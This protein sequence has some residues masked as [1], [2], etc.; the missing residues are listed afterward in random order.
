MLLST[1]TNE[2][3]IDFFDTLLASIQ[4]YFNKFVEAWNAFF[5]D[6]FFA[7]SDET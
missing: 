3:I 5:T 4:T 2:S 1:D 7:T 6:D